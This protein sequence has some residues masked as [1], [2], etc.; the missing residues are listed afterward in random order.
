V[1]I[2]GPIL[3][4]AQGS[5]HVAVAT[6]T[7]LKHGPSDNRYFTSKI[8]SITFTNMRTAV[9]LQINEKYAWAPVK[10]FL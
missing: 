1:V 4:L 5:F 6:G 7:G 8:R 9:I 3:F 10:A 2:T